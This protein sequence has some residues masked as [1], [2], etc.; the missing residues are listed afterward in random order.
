MDFDNL[1][2]IL[3]TSNDGNWKGILYGTLT[4]NEDLNQTRNEN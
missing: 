4:W 2:E 1:S 3:M